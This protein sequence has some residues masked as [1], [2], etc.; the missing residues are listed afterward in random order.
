[1]KDEGLSEIEVYKAEPEKQSHIFWC[2]ENSFCG[3][4]TSET[5]GKL[6]CDQYHPRNGKNGRCKFHSATLYAHGEKIILKIK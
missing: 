2:E 1:M 6:N 3:C 5:C 4:D